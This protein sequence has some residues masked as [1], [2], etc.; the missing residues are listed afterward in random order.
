MPDFS[1]PVGWTDI[2]NQALRSLTAKLI[3]S[4]IEGTPN[5]NFCR[6]FLGKSI[7]QVLAEDDWSAA[8]KRAALNL[9]IE[10]PAHGFLYYYQLPGDYVRFVTTRKANG[11]EV[12]AIDTSGD[13][14]TVEGDKIATNAEAVNIIYIATPADPSKLSSYL[15]N[16]ISSQLALLLCIPLNSNEGLQSQ[17]QGQYQYDLALARKADAKAKKPNTVSDD[18]GFTWWDEAR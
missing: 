6:E 16:A 7:Q 5:A 4:L 2:A 15:R 13:D 14:Y 3:A 17:I 11:A 9:L 10:A 1:Y 8:T 18:L 12:P